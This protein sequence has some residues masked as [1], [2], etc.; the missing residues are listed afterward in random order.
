MFMF[1][2]PRFLLTMDIKMEG[3]IEPQKRDTGQSLTTSRDKIVTVFPA[4]ILHSFSMSFP[5]IALTIWDLLSIVGFI[6]YIAPSLTS[7]AD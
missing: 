4:P 1:K 5:N 2:I 6:N 3:G 7:F